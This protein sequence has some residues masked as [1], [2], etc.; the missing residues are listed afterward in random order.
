MRRI[1][2]LQNQLLIAWSCL[3]TTTTIL[4]TPSTR[5]ISH[6]FST[7]TLT[8]RKSTILSSTS[9]NTDD[10]NKKNNDVAQ[11]LR[12]QA[13]QIRAEI[14][15]MEG[16]TVEQVTLEA[17]QKKNAQ[18]EAERQRIRPTKDKFAKNRS[19]DGKAFVQLPETVDDMIRQAARA[20]ERAYA[21]DNKTRQ[22]VRFHLV[23][24]ENSSNNMYG[25]DENQWPGGAQQMY[26]EAAKPL[27]TALLREVRLPTR[28]RRSA[29]N[30]TDED[31]NT[32]TTTSSSSSSSSSQFAPTIQEQDIWDFDGSALHT[33]QAADGPNGD[34]QALVF[35]NT[36]VKYI[37]DIEEISQ[38]LGPDRLFLLINPFWRNI[39]SW[40]FN[41]LAPGAK[42]KAQKVIFDDT[43]NGAYEE[44]YVN[45]VFQVRGEKCVAI[46]AY[47]YDWQLFAFRE[48][49]D[50]SYYYNSASSA[51]YAIRLGSCKQEPT[52][53]L[54]TAL[55]NER[56]EFKQTKAMR[57][58][59]KLF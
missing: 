20:V 33:A 1:N 50:D 43:E 18:D 24:F 4:L 23:D 34:I 49:D 21:D 54:I 26:R 12:D 8:V 6:A 37:R 46:K 57:Q 19:N 45:M 31:N 22:T 17:Q 9:S 27:T 52:S 56:P 39:D 58:M 13:A 59:K 40:S 28:K 29:S 15:A 11:Q 25:E 51:E 5:N 48:Q 2:M 55:L 7:S 3:F 41:L 30:D 35:P 16:K 42:E 32:T 53:A 10:T 36:D 44:T 47:P 14:A 38:N